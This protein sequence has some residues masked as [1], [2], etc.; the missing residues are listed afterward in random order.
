[1]PSFK[2][3]F[4]EISPALVGWVVSS[5]LLSATIFSLFA[6][7]FSDKLGRTR[8]IGV[9]ALVFAL[10]A[11]LECAAT[12]LPMLIAGRLIVGAGQGLFLSTLL[13]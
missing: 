10:G 13:V 11:A 9:G 8:S 12:N 2:E 7:S 3:S 6:G 1:M 4:G 5:L